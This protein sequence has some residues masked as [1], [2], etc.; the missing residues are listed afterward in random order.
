MDES[1]IKNTSGSPSHRGRSLLIVDSNLQQL[2]SLSKLLQRLEYQAGTAKSA[3][4]ALDMAATT[5]PNL[6]I[7]SLSLADMSGINFMQLLRKTPKISHIPF[8]ALR[9]QEDAP[10]QDCYS[11]GASSCLSI[12]VDLEKLYQAVQAAIEI[13]PR[14]AIR[15]RT[16]QPVKVDTMPFDG[17]SGM[18]TLAL[19][20]RGM[21]LHTMKPAPT[22]T[23]LAL[24]INLNGLI[25]AA[26]ARV[27]YSG[28]SS[29]GTY[30]EPG[31]GLE[32]IQIAPK[33]R[34][35]IRK[36]IHS[37]VTRD[38]DPGSRTHYVA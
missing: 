29:R 22:N 2:A 24:R 9:T 4:E 12:P 10:E 33:D 18:H 20:E 31:V 5:I 13:R 1:G 16:I 38:I 25:I 23:T 21:F 35:F 34:E 32:F 17:Y 27:L 3:Q 36:F 19:S 8:I 26:R 28:Q 37:E 6:I 7:I 14:T 11:V 30:N 15:L